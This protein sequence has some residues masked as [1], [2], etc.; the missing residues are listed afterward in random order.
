MSKEFKDRTFF[1]QVIEIV[2]M[3]I[4]TRLLFRI[5][6]YCYRQLRIYFHKHKS[7]AKFLRFT[8]IVFII[9]YLAFLISVFFFHTPLAPR[10][11][12]KEDVVW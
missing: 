9:Y 12:F 3:F 7:F 2:A 6:Y 1:G 10:S 11:W 5:L 8:F 4:L